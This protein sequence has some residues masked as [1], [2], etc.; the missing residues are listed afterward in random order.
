MTLRSRA[1]RRKAIE[2]WG[3]L[4]ALTEP[5][6]PACAETRQAGSRIQ[7][8]LATLESNRRTV[9]VLTEVKGFTAAEAA[10]AVGAPPRLQ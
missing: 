10:T 1:R 5:R 7:A 3:T 9:F 4:Q 2:Q 6:N 8:A